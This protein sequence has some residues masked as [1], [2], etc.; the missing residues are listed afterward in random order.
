MVLRAREIMT[1]RVVSVGPETPLAVAREWLADSRFSALPVVDRHNRLIGI[2]SAAD[3]VDA[4]SARE[5]T[6]GAVM[7]RDVLYAAPDTDVGV[8]AHRLAAYGGVRVMPIVDRGFL[9]GVVTR[10]DLLRPRPPGGP[11]GRAVQ[12]ALRRLRRHW[13]T[14]GAEPVAPEPVGPSTPRPAER[15]RTAQD[16]MTADPVTVRGTTPVA[17]AASLLTRHRWT[18]VPVVDEHGHLAGIVSEADL[19]RDPLDGRRG[20][21]PRIVAEAMTTDVVSLP[22]EAQ[23]SELARL[24]SRHGLRV[25]PV[26]DGDRL[27]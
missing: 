18:A 20:P 1:D 5:D 10:G 22:P 16:V 4:R 2:V 23:V 19:V 25:V 13:S 27:V 26:V 24:M 3:V 8:I 12:R 21:G 9:V 11:L 17:E 7:T 14:R 15:P 6:V